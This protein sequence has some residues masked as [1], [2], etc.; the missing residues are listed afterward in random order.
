MSLCFLR[1]LSSPLR[2]SPFNLP[3]CFGAG[4]WVFVHNVEFHFAFWEIWRTN[5]VF[6]VSVWSSKAFPGQRV[7]S[8]CFSRPSKLQIMED[9]SAFKDLVV[10]SLMLPAIPLARLCPPRPLC[11]ACGCGE[12]FLLQRD[13]APREAWGKSLS[14]GCGYLLCL[15]QRR[16]VLNF[17]V[18][19][20]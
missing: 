9:A 16:S 3:L 5:N 15:L 13:R 10:R 17:S 6:K 18:L 8:M 1:E 2:A 19:E 14:C 11:K 12:G 20:Q 4:E 7:L